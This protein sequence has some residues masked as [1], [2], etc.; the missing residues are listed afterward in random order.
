[1][2]TKYPVLKIATATFVLFVLP[3]LWPSDTLYPNFSTTPCTQSKLATLYPDLPFFLFL[4]SKEA[5]I[6][7]E[8]LILWPPWRMCLCVVLGSCQ[9][10]FNSVS[11]F[12][13]FLL[14]MSISFCYATNV[15]YQHSSCSSQAGARKVCCQ[16][17]LISHF[18]Q[19]TGTETYSCN[20]IGAI[21]MRWE[22]HF[23]SRF[24]T[25]INNYTCVCN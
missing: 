2:D 20:C 6:R 11:L 3:S 16:I 12:H 5:V 14:W 10:T 8:A 24:T 1:M 4:P 15:M 21:W 19:Y 9:M 25:S 23:F 18:V 17:L 7:F 13:T 22:T